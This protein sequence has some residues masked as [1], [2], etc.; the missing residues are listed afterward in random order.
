MAGREA[1][2]CRDCGDVTATYGRRGYKSVHEYGTA[3]G[4]SG[5]AAQYHHPECGPF[6]WVDSASEPTE[7]AARRDTQQ[8]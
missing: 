6:T 5:L 1:V 2:C 4:Y 3:R 8:Y 7:R